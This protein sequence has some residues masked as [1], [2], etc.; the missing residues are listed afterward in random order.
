MGRVRLGMILI[1]IVAMPALGLAQWLR[2]PT[3]DVP[4]TA[5]G[6]PNLNAAP[7]R[8]PDG[9]PD[10]SGLWHVTLRNPCN[11]ALTGSAAAP[12]WRVADRTESRRESP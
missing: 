11:A 10:F 9:T 1:V 2:Y 5:D 3:A 12:N 7:P 6:K 4:R 8:L